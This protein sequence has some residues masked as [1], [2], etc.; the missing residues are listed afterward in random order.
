MPNLCA[1]L[2]V[3]QHLSSASKGSYF[4]PSSPKKFDLRRNSTLD[5]YSIHCKKTP[6]TLDVKCVGYID[7]RI[8]LAGMESLIVQIILLASAAREG[9][10]QHHV[11]STSLISTQ[12]DILYQRRHFKTSPQWR[13]F[14]HPL[15]A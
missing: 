7:C 1:E 2:R 8:H 10:I 13:D 6:S 3:Y 15:L 9:G 4:F 5:G 14:G 12:Y 11:I